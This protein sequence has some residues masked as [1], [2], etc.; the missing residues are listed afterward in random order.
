MRGTPLVCLVPES[1]ASS[2]DMNEDGKR[3]KISVTNIIQK[4]FKVFVEDVAEAV[5][6]LI[7]R[8]KSIVTDCKLEESYNSASSL[9]NAKK[10]PSAT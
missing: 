1:A 10:T 4:Y 7:R 2:K 6:Q 5:I 8:H 3:V 9:I